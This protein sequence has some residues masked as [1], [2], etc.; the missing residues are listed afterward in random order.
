MEVALLN[1]TSGSAVLNQLVLSPEAPSQHSL[2]TWKG[3]RQRCVLTDRP[4]STAGAGQG[5][6]APVPPY[7][8]PSTALRVPAASRK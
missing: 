8:A 6:E 1:S 4:W 5:Q 7:T 3:R 2:A